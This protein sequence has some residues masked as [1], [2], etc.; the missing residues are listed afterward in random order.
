MSRCRTYWP[1]AA[2]GSRRTGPCEG[3]Q[4]GA[5]ERI[6]AGERGEVRSHVA[7]VVRV[8]EDRALAREHVADVRDLRALLEVDQVPRRVPRGEHRA[9]G[10]PGAELD[11]IA[12]REQAVNRERHSRGG[13]LVRG[14]RRPGAST[15]LVRVADVIAVV[16]GEQDQRER[17]PGRNRARRAAH[18]GARARRRAA[19]RAR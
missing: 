15:Q 1:I 18:R 6:D 16:V 12:V 5:A 8:D 13:L 10:D 2:A 7:A 19:S 14:D 4:R 3:D 9:Q 11:V 17:M